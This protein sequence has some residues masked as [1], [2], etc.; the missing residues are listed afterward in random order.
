MR[1]TIAVTDSAQDQFDGIDELHG[2]RGH[3]AVQEAM[4]QDP[5]LDVASQSSWASGQLRLW[6]VSFVLFTPALLPYASHF[7]FQKPGRLATGF[8]DY[9]MPYYLANAREHFDEGRF[10]FFYSNPYDPN[11]ASPAIYSQPMTLAL[12]TIMHL[13]GIAPNHLFLLFELVAGWVCARVAVA[14]YA[15]VVGLSDWARR[16]GLVVFFWGAGLM[17]LM[18]IPYSLVTEGAVQQLFVLDPTGGFW[19]L[20]FGRNMVYPTESLYHALS[21]GCFLCVLRR[22]YWLATVLALLLSWSTP[23]SGV[24]VILILAC[25]SALE[26][27]FVRS[28]EVPISFLGALVALLGLHLGYYV[29]FLRRF[30]EH[31]MLMEQWMLQY[32]LQADNFVPAYALVGALAAWSFRRLDLARQFF[33]QPR[34]RFFLVWFLVAFAL[35][36]NE[37]AIK[38]IQPLHFTRGYIWTPL[39][40]MGAPALLGLFRTLR[41]RSGPRL[42]TAAVGTVVAVLLLDN[43]IWLNSFAWEGAHGRPAKYWSVTADQLEL[44]R[45]LSQLENRGAL[46]ITSDPHDV[47]FLAAVYTPLRPWFGHVGNTPDFKARRK[48]V[49]AFLEEGTVIDAW[50]GK[51][52]LVTLDRPIPEPRWLSAT[53]T[54]PVYEN[55]GYRVYRVTPATKPPARSP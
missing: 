35:A 12:G 6:L 40:L 48:E 27:F 53:G 44:Y 25:W 39:F 7:L 20:N 31:R 17:V 13:T 46:L 18:G 36:N 37:F 21:F 47:G 23:F 55:A 8:F 22:K 54:E 41:S 4:T 52:L 3:Q 33:A 50:R 34:N 5:V 29:G 16:L 1:P 51:T 10:R 9:D 15:E 45:W 19:M 30:P 11:Y 38:P 24:E 32:F 43:A 42:G 2:P 14:L 49:A 26:L 28:R